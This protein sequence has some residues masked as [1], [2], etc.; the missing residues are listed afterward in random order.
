MQPLKS[1]CILSEKFACHKINGKYPE[2]S[3]E[4]QLQVCHSLISVFTEGGEY[5]WNSGA[6]CRHYSLQDCLEWCSK[7]T[8][9]I[10]A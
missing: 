3:N 10:S 5:G 8:D 2:R 1:S 7:P 6:A 9:V 4:N